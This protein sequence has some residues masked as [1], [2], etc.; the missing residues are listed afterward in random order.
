MTDVSKKKMGPRRIKAAIKAMSSKEMGSCKASRV[1][2]I[3]LPPHSS[4]KMQ[5][6][7]EAFMGPSKTAKQ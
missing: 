2:I 4:H 5:P 7:D 6:V 1:Y 3:C